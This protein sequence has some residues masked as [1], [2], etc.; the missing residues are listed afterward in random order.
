MKQL[1]SDTPDQRMDRDVD[2]LQLQ[3]DTD[4]EPRDAWKG[5]T[6][7][8]VFSLGDWL[9]VCQRLDIPYVPATKVAT[10]A[11]EKLLAFDARPEDPDL[12]AFLRAVESAKKPH[13][14]LRWDACAPEVVKARLSKGQFG[15]DAEVLE[16]FTIDD[17][18]AFDILYEHPA[19]ETCVWS[20]PWVSAA[21]HEKYPVEY[22][23]LVHEG[24]IVGVSNYYPQRALRWTTA[25][26]DDVTWAVAA[27][28]RLAEALPT[29]VRFGV[30][31]KW[32]DPDSCSFTAD[33][34]RLE[35][36]E[37][38]FL[39]A[40]PPFGAGAHPCCFPDDPK[41]WKTATAHRHEMIPVA[42]ASTSNDEE[43][44]DERNAL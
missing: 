35:T 36:G 18:R 43:K 31:A 24:A 37:R 10:I 33:F 4:S 38:M 9:A 15:W 41:T 27:T 44:K 25:V 23:V 20:R 17:P 16:W 34:M 39:E 12:K 30:A 13:T 6:G 8:N 26:Q 32:F 22:R 5:Q 2:M 21:T 40:G 14:M 1:D 3:L 19:C 29:P 11:I 28:R 7:F 42:L